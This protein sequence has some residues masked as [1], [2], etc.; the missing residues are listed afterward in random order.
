MDSVDDLGATIEALELPAGT[1][2]SITEKADNAAAAAERGNSNAARNVLGAFINRIE[3]QRG[4]KISDEEAQLLI[5]F[6][7]NAIGG[8]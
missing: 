2:S 4:K 6:A 3:A 7:L 8:L 1:P 5:D